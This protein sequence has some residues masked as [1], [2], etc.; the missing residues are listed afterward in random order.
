[1]KLKILLLSWTIIDSFK[2]LFFSPNYLLNIPNKQCITQGLVCGNLV[3]MLAFHSKNAFQGNMQLSST[4][5]YY[6]KTDVLYE[7]LRL[8]LN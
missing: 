3:E 1:M 8:K 2:K 6:S 5:F 4:Q 7:I